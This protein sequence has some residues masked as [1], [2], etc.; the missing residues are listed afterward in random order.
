MPKLDPILGRVPGT[1]KVKDFA[2]S[3][4]VPASSSMSS[5]NTAAL[6]APAHLRNNDKL[7]PNILQKTVLKPVESSHF[8][9]IT[10]NTQLDFIQSGPAIPLPAEI[11]VFSV[12]YLNHFKGMTMREIQE[13]IARKYP[14]LEGQTLIQDFLSLIP[15]Y[16]ELQ[17][18]VYKVLY[19][20]PGGKVYQVCW[21]RKSSCVEGEGI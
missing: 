15:S 10:S 5:L 16:L 9:T 12:F 6:P 3:R 14:R 2:L 19:P 8:S 4:M 13:D 17:G 7:Q 21:G 20:P 18:G 11:L 1:I